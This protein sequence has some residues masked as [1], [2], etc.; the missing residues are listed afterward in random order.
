MPCV[1]RYHLTIVEAAKSLD[2]GATALKT[3]LR[4]WGI[5]RWPSRKYNSVK[6]LILEVQMYDP[7]GLQVEEKQLVLDRLQ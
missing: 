7:Q 2:I 3:F 5:K 1:Q 6:K 4:K